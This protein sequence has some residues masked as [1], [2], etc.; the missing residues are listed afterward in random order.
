MAAWDITPQPLHN[1]GLRIKTSGTRM[2]PHPRS[3]RVKMHA[4]ALII[5][6][7]EAA[8]ETKVHVKDPTTK[9]RKVTTWTLLAHHHHSQQPV[10]NE[11]EPASE[12]MIITT[13]IEIGIV[14]TII[15]I[16]T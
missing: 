11:A 9:W 5:V 10:M 14:P 6:S 16:E 12:D 7:E 13:K 3:Q 15:D 4:L 8:T 2:A 1:K